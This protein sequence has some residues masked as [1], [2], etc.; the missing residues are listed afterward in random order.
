MITFL[1]GGTGTPKLLQ[2]V[3]ALVPDD[4]IAVVVNTAEDLWI[5]GNHLSPD[6]DTVTYLFAGTLNTDT[7]WGMRGDTFVTHEEA[8]RLGADEFIAIGDRDRAV[9]IAR[10]GLLRQGRTLTE[11]TSDICRALGVRARV[12]PMCDT[13]VASMVRTPSGWVHF[14]E[15]WIRRRGEVDITEIVRR[16]EVPPVLTDKARRAILESEAVIIGPSNPVTSI[17]PIL[18]CGGVR[19]LLGKL[20]VIAVSPFIG[21]RPV[22]GPAYALMK[23]AGMKPGSYGTYRL[24]QDFTDL[25]VQDIRDTEEVPGA[26]KLDTLMTDTSRSRDLAERILARIPELSASYG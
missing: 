7:W 20:P 13:A 3:R 21:D 19:E 23:A 1:S 8:K 14:Q 16:S 18:E 5:S 2:G 17:L 11:A 15:Y 6:V 26:I 12:L 4:G 9:H 10:G 24:Y 25:F 22:S